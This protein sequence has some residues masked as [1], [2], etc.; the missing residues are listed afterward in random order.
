MEKKR[1]LCAIEKE[2][3]WPQPTSQRKQKLP[4]KKREAK[5]EGPVNSSKN[6]LHSPVDVGVRLSEPVA[7][8]IC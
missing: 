3:C 5:P 1:S 6:G 8:W 4:R 2:G 7:H